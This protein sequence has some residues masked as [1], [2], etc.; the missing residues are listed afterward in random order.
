MTRL[1]LVLLAACGRADRPWDPEDAP[2]TNVVVIVADDVGIDKIAAYRAHPSPP[3]TPNLDALA[4]EGLLFRNAWSAPTCTP[5]RVGL[6]TGQHGR[7]W[8]SNRWVHPDEDWQ[9]PVRAFTVPDLL[10]EAPGARWSH[11]FVGKWHLTDFGH[12]D[13]A[14]HPLDHGWDWY[15]GALGNLDK[16][17]GQHDRPGTYR[18]W[19]KNDNGVLE[20]T[21][22]YATT[23]TVDDAVARLDAMEPPWV[24][25]VSL[26]AAHVP[27][28]TPPDELAT[29][30]ADP[31]DPDRLDAIVTAMDA[32]LG[33]LLA[34]VPGDATILF[35]GDNGTTVEGVRPPWDPGQSKGTLTEGGVHVPL[36][37]AGPLVSQPGTE[38]AALVHVLDV[39]ATL[40]D[41]AGVDPD[42]LPDPVA[43]RSLLP[44]L[45]DPDLPGAD[46][47]FAAR[48]GENG[49]R[50]AGE[51]FA[52]RDARYKLVDCGGEQLFDLKGRV[53]DGPDLLRGSLSD[54]AAARLRE[55]RKELKEAREATPYLGG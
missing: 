22:T 2:R 31:S 45:E 13:P 5:T 38:T 44:V 39:F 40:G 32:E 28:T 11:S 24:L 6:V 43:S 3:A 4:A 54:E 48:A 52:V 23:D 21:Q 47:L 49:P 35:L 53:D 26:N 8:G 51:C 36:I 15:A 19:Q 29:V 33:R 20:W 55:L 41:N 14:M 10:A 25:W 18:D 12:G 1:G 34:A 42:V 7:Q 9:L 50:P 46:T 16:Y 17:I 30:P 37:A 27:F